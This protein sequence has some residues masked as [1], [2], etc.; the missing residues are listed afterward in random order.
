MFR[1]FI[2]YCY[3]AAF[4]K[5]RKTMQSGLMSITGEGAKKFLQGQLTCNIEEITTEPVLAAHCNP[6]GRIISLFWIHSEHDGFYLQMPRELIP[7]AL[8]ALK[9]YAVFFKVTLTDI[10]DSQAQADQTALNVPKGIPA[11]YP[12]TSE[13]FLPHEL[14]LHKLNAIS[15]NKGC[16]T[17]QEIIARMHY[18][19][20]LKTHMY[21]AKTQSDSVPLRGAAIYNAGGTCGTLVDYADVGYNSYELLV[22][23]AE[24]DI[25]MPLYL[26]PEQQ[27]RLEILELPYSL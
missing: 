17:G 3:S 23:I 10:S 25:G 2:K 13:K 15:F 24:A 9:K 22:V 7:I 8:A 18:R 6:Q 12:E 11:I 14:N 16:Y 1:F 19:G 4:I 26:H 5:K 20:K 27:A 21:R